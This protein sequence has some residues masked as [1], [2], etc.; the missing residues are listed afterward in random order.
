LSFFIAGFR[1][2]P[3]TAAL[4]GAISALKSASKDKWI[5]K[6]CAAVQHHDYHAAKNILAAGHGHLA[7]GI[8][9]L[10]A[11]EA[12]LHGV[13]AGGSQQQRNFTIGSRAIAQLYCSTAFWIS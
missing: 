12:A 10:A 1:N 6:D 11:Q 9:L 5:C 13:K 3:V 2:F 7:G 8:P 4:R